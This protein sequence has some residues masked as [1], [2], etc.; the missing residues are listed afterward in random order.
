MPDGRCVA[1]PVC[2]TGVGVIASAATTGEHGT[3]VSW[4]TTAKELLTAGK[5][6]DLKASVVAS[7][8]ACELLH[9]MG[10]ATV[11]QAAAQRDL[12]AHEAVILNP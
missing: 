4:L 2:H 7:R 8:E 1:V 10:P 12:A 3:I 11:K 5:P 6:E 9:K